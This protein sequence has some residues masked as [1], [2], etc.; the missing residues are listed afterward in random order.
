MPRATL[1]ALQAKLEYSLLRL[2]ENYV[3]VFICGGAE[4][5]DLLAAE[6][7]LA[8]KPDFPQVQ[9]KLYLPF[10]GHESRFSAQNKARFYAIR[11]RADEVR[12]ISDAYFDGCFIKRDHAMVDDGHVCVC[13]MTRCRSG[14]GLTMRYAIKKGLTTMNLADL[15]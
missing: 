11:E 3:D 15:I 9:L 13:Y 14:T 7:V 4:G 5:F 1:P 2:A 10:P 8:L 12:Y 6:A